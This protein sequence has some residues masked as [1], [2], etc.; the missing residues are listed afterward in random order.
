MDRSFEKVE[1]KNG[2]K[3]FNLNKVGNCD[4]VEVKIIKQFDHECDIC[5]MGF[6]DNYNLS[7]HKYMRHNV[8]IEHDTKIVASKGNADNE[9]E[10]TM[11]CQKCDE[12]FKS[13]NIFKNHI[14]TYHSNNDLNQDY[15]K[16]LENDF[17]RDSEVVAIYKC[18]HC[19]KRFQN[20]T[21]VYNHKVNYHNNSILKRGKDKTCPICEITFATVGLMKRHAKRRS[22]PCD[23]CKVTFCNDLR[24]NIHKVMCKKKKKINFSKHSDNTKA[25]KH[26]I[27]V[28]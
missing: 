17:N 8:K 19:C 10:L 18:D 21:E 26:V 1:N 4:D 3:T 12:T 15:L 9:K 11:T 2:N 7:L 23:F 6:I 20:V 16:N 5:N 13:K 25:K 28:E 27:D 22:L 14:K 24:L